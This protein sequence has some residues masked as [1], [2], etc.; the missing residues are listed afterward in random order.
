[1]PEKHITMPKKLA[2]LALKVWNDNNR[3]EQYKYPTPVI[4]RIVTEYIKKNNFTL[5]NEELGIGQ[6]N[7]G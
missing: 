3:L 4:K 1:M 5:L 2:E 6:E 7:T